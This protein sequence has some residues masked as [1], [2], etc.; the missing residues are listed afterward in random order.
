MAIVESDYTFDFFLC[1]LSP[2]ERVGDG[3][4]KNMNRENL[5]SIIFLAALPVS[6]V[7]M[8]RQ[9]RCELWTYYCV[10]HTPHLHCSTTAAAQTY[11]IMVMF[12]LCLNVESTYTCT[13]RILTGMTKKRPRLSYKWFEA[14][15]PFTTHGALCQSFE[16]TPLW[17]PSFVHTAL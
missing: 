14:Q 3:W 12:S 7:C 17:P 11:H 1:K 16:N 8:Y 4:S 10:G 2:S 9:K 6:T 13:T 15:W 5:S